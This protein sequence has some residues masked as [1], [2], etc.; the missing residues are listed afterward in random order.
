MLTEVVEVVE[1]VLLG[2]LF[3]T[4]WRQCVEPLVV[5]DSTRPLP[6]PMPNN[7]AQVIAGAQ[8]CS[9]HTC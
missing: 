9:N 1:V 3:S 7:T 4:L 5:V 2:Q 6:S 8:S